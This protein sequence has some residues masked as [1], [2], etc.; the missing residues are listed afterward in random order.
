[1]SQQSLYKKQREK[2]ERILLDIKDLESQ[3][4]QVQSAISSKRQSVSSLKEKQLFQKQAIQ[5]FSS[6]KQALKD[7]DNESTLKKTNEHDLTKLLSRPDAICKKIE[8]MIE[9]QKDTTLTNA[10]LTSLSLKIKDMHKYNFTD[11]EHL[12]NNTN[13]MLLKEQR[14]TS[15]ID[16]NNSNMDE[17]QERIQQLEEEQRGRTAVVRELFDKKFNLE[18]ETKKAEYNLMKR[19]NELHSDP[20]VRKALFENLKSKSQGHQLYVELTVL[21]KEAEK[22][23]SQYESSKDQLGDDEEEDTSANLQD[24]PTALKS[25][26]EAQKKALELMVTNEHYVKHLNQQHKDG[27]SYLSEETESLLTRLETAKSQLLLLSNPDNANT[28]TSNK[29]EEEDYL[30][31][32]KNRASPF[33]NISTARTISEL[34]SLILKLKEQD[35]I[36][37][38]PN[39]PILLKSLVNKWV[40]EDCSSAEINDGKDIHA[41]INGVK[42]DLENNNKE[43]MSKHVEFIQT[44]LKHAESIQ[45]EV[46]RTKEALKNR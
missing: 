14:S 29:E 44:K 43:Y 8:Y 15:D 32:L 2:T 37:K 40:Q 33:T 5:H 46:N 31:K 20:D 21:E 42:D 19:I 6:L 12:I 23:F 41:F 45:R 25:L 35:R 3:I 34:G 4:E 30:K 1:M 13:T 27:N 24:I 36:T 18:A 38:Y 7:D 28:D 26:K 16:N 39:I 9:K 10:E 17:M 22:M 11:I